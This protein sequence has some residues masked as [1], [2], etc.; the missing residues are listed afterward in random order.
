MKLFV[1]PILIILVLSGCATVDTSGEWSKVKDYTF[2]KTGIEA[3]W[4]KHK[5]ER[6]FINKEIERLLSDGLTRDD[7]VWIS[8]LNN[9]RLQSVFEEIGIAK[10]ELV[11]AGLLKN[12]I[13]SAFFKLPLSG[14]PTGFEIEG[15]FS[16]LDLWQIKPRKKIA[17]A[18]LEAVILKVYEEILNTSIEAKRLYYEYVLSSYMKD[19][20]EKI[21]N[22]TDNLKEQVK[23]FGDFGFSNELDIKRANI[24][25]LE[26]EIEYTSI[27]TSLQLARMN[28]NRIMGFM[29]DKMDYDIIKEIS[30]DAALPSDI[31]KLIDKAFSN[32]LDL[33][34]NELKINEATELLGLEYRGI[35]EELEA[36]LSY[37]KKTEGE[38]FFTPSLRFSIPI[39]NTNRA[40]IAKAEFVLRQA[41]KELN[42]TKLRIREDVLKTVERMKEIRQKIYIIKE[43]I[44]PKQREAVQYAEKYFNA[45]Q[46]NLLQVI[47]ARIELLKSQKRLFE[48]MLEK[49][50]TELELEKAIGGIL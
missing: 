49:K 6:D 37:E 3:V 43:L 41:V 2:K 33:K 24:A 45:M 20:I 15:V 11:Q 27:E 35:I 19:E 30:E 18:R 38:E 7:A 26:Q 17:S 29:P 44:I 8:I 22:E 36:G 4:E 39:F 14:G 46:L 32:R 16:L 50:R 48:E 23:Y 5:S 40:Q 25:A 10:A 12:P 47:E 28:L 42:E 21:K 31:S 13:V 9:P 34:I 1:Y